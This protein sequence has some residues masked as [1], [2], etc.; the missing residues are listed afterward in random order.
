MQSLK[1]Q[2]GFLSALIPAA[3]SLIGGVMRNNSAKSA[4]ADANQV[5]VAMQQDSQDF[6]AKEAQ[7]NRD[8]QER[9]ANSAHQREVTDLRAAGL[10]PILSGTGGMGSM[11][12]GGAAASSSGGQ[13][14]KADIQD[15]ISPAITTAAQARLLNAQAD[16]Q[17]QIE[18][19]EKSKADLL[20][21]I[22]QGAA[23]RIGQG[24]DAINN[25][26]DHL[27]GT[28][29]SAKSHPLPDPG[30]IIS[31]PLEAVKNWIRA[32]PGKALD[33]LN[34]SAA[35]IGRKDREYSTKTNP[36]KWDKNHAPMGKPKGT[37]ERSF[38]STWE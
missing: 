32:L 3:A 20:E 12:P 27:S 1:K 13:G 7:L 8:F 33:A 24:M 18:R 2:A 5:S 30:E 38:G 34:S 26:V 36:K 6:N 17:K 9:L 31:R 22:S 11:T 21:P 35:Q 16:T 14:N 4:A 25:L 37:Q 28:T 15:V 10:N 23:P 19:Q 29:S